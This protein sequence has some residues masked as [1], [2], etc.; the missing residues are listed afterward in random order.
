LCAVF[1][2]EIFY[3]VPSFGKTGPHTHSLGVFWE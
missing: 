2:P 3:F 1:H